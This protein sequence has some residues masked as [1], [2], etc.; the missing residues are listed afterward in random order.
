M[1]EP[2][3]Y[4]TLNYEYTIILIHPNN[5]QLQM[6][7]FILKQSCEFNDWKVFNLP[8][9]RCHC[10]LLWKCVPEKIT[11]TLMFTSLNNQQKV[12]ENH[13]EWTEGVWVQS[14]FTKVKSVQY[15]VKQYVLLTLCWRQFWCAYNL[16]SIIIGTVNVCTTTVSDA[17]RFITH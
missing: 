10:R 4:L 3:C 11:D 14:P 8:T 12:I 1:Y 16:R 2:T 9:S 6:L 15:S 13:G 7:M 5:T 17:Q